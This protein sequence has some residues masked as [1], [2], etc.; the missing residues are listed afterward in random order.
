MCETKNQYACNFQ[1]TECTFDGLLL[2]S[3]VSYAL[4]HSMIIIVSYII[5]NV[6]GSGRG[7]LNTAGFFSS[8]C[9]KLRRT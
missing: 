2:L 9:A 1:R 4:S 7:L 3:S 6:K 5:G 8:Y